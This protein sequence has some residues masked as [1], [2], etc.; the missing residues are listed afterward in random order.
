MN[1]RT[2][3]TLLSYMYLNCVSV[4]ICLCVFM[5]VPMRAGSYIDQRNWSSLES[6]DMGAGNWSQVLHKSSVSPNLW[7][8]SPGPFPISWL[9]FLSF[10]IVWISRVTDSFVCHW[11]WPVS[12]SLCCVLSAPSLLRC[13]VF[14][15]CFLRVCNFQHFVLPLFNVSDSLSTKLLGCWHSLIVCVCVRTTCESCFLR[16][17]CGLCVWNSVHQAR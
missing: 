9:F 16:P 10:S 2:V 3:V 17:L 5:Y 13:S 15:I 1:V 8:I 12:L 11:T 4:F 14:P 6:L 7:D